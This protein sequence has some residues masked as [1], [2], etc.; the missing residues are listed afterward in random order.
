MCDYPLRS[1]S[2]FVGL[3][4][5]HFS[6][7]VRIPNVIFSHFF[8]KLCR[9]IKIYSSENNKSTRLNVH[10]FAEF[11]NTQ[12]AV[13]YQKHFRFSTNA[14]SSNDHVTVRV[15]HYKPNYNSHQ[16]QDVLW[17]CWW[18]LSTRRS[19]NDS[20]LGRQWSENV[21]ISWVWPSYTMIRFM[22]NCIMPPYFWL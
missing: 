14:L 16:S 13:S 18:H 21:N 20:T 9:L 2:C 15:Y 10:A 1:S 17:I 8:Y 7:I 5:F 4:L 3:D 11:D 19:E 12:I 6:V 22:V